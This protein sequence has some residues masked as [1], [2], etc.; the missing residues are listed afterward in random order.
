LGLYSFGEEEFN[1][2]LVIEAGGVDLKLHA[3]EKSC[4]FIEVN[5]FLEMN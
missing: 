3:R 1:K 2:P 4:C 5:H